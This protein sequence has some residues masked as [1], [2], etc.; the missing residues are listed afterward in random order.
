[1]KTV[2]IGGVAILAVFLLVLLFIPL[3]IEPLTEVYFENH[4]TLPAYLFLDKP[5]NF[6]FTIHNLEYQEMKLK[7]GRQ[8]YIGELLTDLKKW[9]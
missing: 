6:S 2:V 7:A 4:T 9:V 8:Q 1:M 5:Y 3:G